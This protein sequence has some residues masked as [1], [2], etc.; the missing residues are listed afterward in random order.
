[1]SVSLNPSE[2]NPISAPNAPKKTTL[3]NISTGRTRDM[4]GMT[5]QEQ[6]QALE[7]ALKKSDAKIVAIHKS[8]ASLAGT[9]RS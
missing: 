1:M 6:L 8:L 3:P 7:K 5:F 4:H 2:Q 9:I